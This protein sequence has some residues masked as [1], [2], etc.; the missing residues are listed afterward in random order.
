MEVYYVKHMFN[1]MTLSLKDLEKG[2]L[3]NLRPAVS[4]VPNASSLSQL[5]QWLLRAHAGCG[6]EFT[7]VL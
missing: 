4:V 3:N 7:W 2:R 6:L 5:T 1:M